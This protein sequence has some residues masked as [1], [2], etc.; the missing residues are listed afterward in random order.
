MQ[1]LLFTTYLFC[2]YSKLNIVTV[3]L[4]LKS[5]VLRHVVAIM[6]LLLHTNTRIYLLLITILF[7]LLLL[8]FCQYCCCISIY[9]KTTPRILQKVV[10]KR[11]E[12][13]Q[14]KQ[15]KKKITLHS[16][17]TNAHTCIQR[18]STPFILSWTCN[19]ITEK[20]LV[21]PERQ[22]RERRYIDNSNDCS[23]SNQSKQKHN[24]D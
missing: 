13:E 17:K 10:E 21:S 4:A 8:L 15:Q 16:R 3:Y 6:R 7:G 1:P 19:K 24:Q 22:A 9:T 12:K 23:A 5:C 18:D 2:L 20:P 11:L 14:Q